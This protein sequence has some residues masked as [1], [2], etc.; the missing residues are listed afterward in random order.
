MSTPIIIEIKATVITSSGIFISKED[1]LIFVLV[2][3]LTD[4]SR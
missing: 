2:L 3:N 1:F 4:M